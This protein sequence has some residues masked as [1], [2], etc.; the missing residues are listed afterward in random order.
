VI[1]LLPSDDKRQLQAARTNSLLIRYN[2]L[3]LAVLVFLGLAIGITYVYLNTVKASSQSV[4]D[5]N[6]AR[7]SSYA[8]VQNE[9][10][11]FRSNLA[12]AKEILSREVTYSDVVLD[13][14]ALLPPGVVLQ[15]LSLDANTFGTPTVLIAN[16]KSYS[17]AIALKN[18]FQ[19]SSLFSD[20]HFT[21]ITSTT[22]SDTAGQYPVTVNIS[23]TIKKGVAK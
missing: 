12:T 16:A 22:S 1:N 21:S 14:A 23:V 20:V 4:I 11:Q 8:P 9:A 3:M 10:N 19:S 13:I 2:I 6:Q 18:S 17:S 5:G 15:N 7:V